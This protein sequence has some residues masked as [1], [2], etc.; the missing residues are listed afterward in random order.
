M[1]L[2]TVVHAFAR[3]AIEY[4]VIER[5]EDGTFVGRVPQLPG[6]IAFGPSREDCGKELLTVIEDWAK[7]RVERGRRVPA[8]GDIDLNTEENRRLVLE[9]S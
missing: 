6:V 3:E 5:L 1:Y 9:H 2:P 8:L 7:F 4:A